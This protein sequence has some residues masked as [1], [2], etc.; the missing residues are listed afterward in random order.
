M[1]RSGKKGHK[2]ALTQGTL[3]CYNSKTTSNTRNIFKVTI[4]LKSKGIA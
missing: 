4:H 3:G 2:K 1:I